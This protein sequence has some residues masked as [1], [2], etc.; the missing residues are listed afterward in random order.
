M[1][2][3]I[4]DCVDEQRER[5]TTEHT[6]QRHEEHTDNQPL[7]ESDVRVFVWLESVDVQ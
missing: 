6:D 2:S 5:T 7:E 3:Y 1:P 4:E